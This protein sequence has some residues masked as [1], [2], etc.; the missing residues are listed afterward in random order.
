MGWH[1]NNFSVSPTVASYLGLLFFQG[2]MPRDVDMAAWTAGSSPRAGFVNGR[3]PDDLCRLASNAMLRQCR[4]HLGFNGLVQS[5][6]CE[7]E[8]QTRIG[9]QSCLD[10]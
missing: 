7:R 4:S 5:R 6:P 2:M 9:N 8:A 3:G 10:A 1:G